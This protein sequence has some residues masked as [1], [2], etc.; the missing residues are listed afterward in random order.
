[1]D[2]VYLVVGKNAIVSSIR[3]GCDCFMGCI[4]PSPYMPSIQSKHSAFSILHRSRSFQFWTLAM[5]SRSSACCASCSFR[6]SPLRIVE[7][8]FLFRHCTSRASSAVSETVSETVAIAAGTAG[9]VIVSDVTD[10]ATLFETRAADTVLLYP[11]CHCAIRTSVAVSY[12]R[13]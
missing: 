7:F 4:H 12:P 13:W 5:A 11:R 10:D 6:C 9:G 1:M 2:S 8:V 3:F